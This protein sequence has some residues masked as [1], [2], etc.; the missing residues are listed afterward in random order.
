MEYRRGQHPNSRRNLKPFCKGQIANPEG[1][2]GRTWIERQTRCRFDAAVQVLKSQRLDPELYDAVIEELA[3]CII[4]GALRD[5]RFTFHRLV[6][7][8]L[9]H[10]L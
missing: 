7:Y 10:D 8:A 6:K 4:A 5:D 3:S 2:N 9:R 1:R